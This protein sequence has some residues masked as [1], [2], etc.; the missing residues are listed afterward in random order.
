MHFTLNFIAAEELQLVASMDEEAN[1][2]LKLD[3]ELQ[4]IF[5]RECR[6]NTKLTITISFRYF[7]VR[8]IFLVETFV[9]G[10][11]FT[12]LYRKPHF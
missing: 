1:K 10:Y 7:P 2:N 11:F 8:F 5:H 4:D 6:S 3:S 12:L 9:V